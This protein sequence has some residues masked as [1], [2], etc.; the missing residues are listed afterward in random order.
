MKIGYRYSLPLIFLI[1]PFIYSMFYTFPLGD[2][3]GRALEARWIFDWYRGFHHMGLQW[4]HWCG[5]FTHTFFV[6]FLGDAAL[7]RAGYG[8]VCTSIISLYAIALHGIYRHVTA[9]RDN[10]SALFFSLFGIA[11]ILAWHTALPPSYF[12]LTD[13]LGIGVG[14]GMVLVFIF[15]LCRLWRADQSNWQDTV[16]AVVTA[17]CAIGFYEHAALATLLA[18]LL[19]LWMAHECS[20][21][22]KAAF[23]RVAKWVLFFFLVAFLAPGNFKRQRKRDVTLDRIIEQLMQVGHDW[24]TLIPG[25]M[26]SKLTAGALFMGIMLT[27]RHRQDCSSI[28]ALRIIIASCVIFCALSL[29]IIT[30]HAL[31]DAPILPASKLPASMHLLLCYVM[32]FAVSLSVTQ[33]RHHLQRIPRFMVAVPMIALLA[34][35]NTVATLHSITSGELDN[36]SKFLTVRYDL[37]STSPDM[38]I[39]VAPLLQCPSPACVGESMTSSIDAWPAANVSK[40]YGKYSVTSAPRTPQAAWEHA[41]IPPQAW[42]QLS[43]LPVQ[44]APTITLSGPNSTYTGAWLFLRGAQASTGIHVLMVPRAIANLLPLRFSQAIQDR[45]FGGDTIQSPDSMQNFFASRY[46][47]ATTRINT[48]TADT[49]IFAM[50]LPVNGFAD[51]AA[52]F[53]SID[54]TTFHRVSLQHP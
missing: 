21:P 40:L 54:G 15:A 23:V 3:F 1:A 44:V 45:L 14:N 19:A 33:I 52:M 34:T 8:I 50:P 7:S 11:S 18:A 41:Q 28:S 27:P 47:A 17:A 9:S 42:Q 39:I 12:L 43:S 31:S 29:S 46:A 51:M 6:V 10:A 49:D 25:M 24:I 36:Y 13:I 35:P 48:D 32:T 4:L 53:V 20:H 30:V 5:R 22:N 38:R 16:F 26:L 2:D 37:L